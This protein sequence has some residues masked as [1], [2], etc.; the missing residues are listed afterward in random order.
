MLSCLDE[1]YDKARHDK[2]ERG[3]PKLENQSVKDRFSMSYSF[4]VPPPD[5]R[6]FRRHT[7]SALQEEIEIPTP[8][9]KRK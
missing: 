3:K 4:L 7:H 6:L 5:E 9:F 1:V 2:A 8:A